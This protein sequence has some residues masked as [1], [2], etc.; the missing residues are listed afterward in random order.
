MNIFDIIIVLLSLGE[1]LFFGGSGSALSALRV[2]IY[3]FI[4]ISR[5]EYLEHLGF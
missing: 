4:F 3:Y 2:Y 5:L 1:L